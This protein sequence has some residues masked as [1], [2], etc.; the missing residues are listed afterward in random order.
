MFDE[1]SNLENAKWWMQWLQVHVQL[2]FCYFH[3]YCKKIYILVCV[4]D[5]VKQLQS[6]QCFRKINKKFDC[7]TVYEV[8]G[9]CM[10]NFILTC[11]KHDV[12][13]I[14]HRWG[15]CLLGSSHRAWDVDCEAELGSKRPC[16]GLWFHHVEGIGAGQSATWRPPPRGEQ[17]GDSNN[18]SGT[19]ERE[20]RNENLDEEQERWCL[21]M[22]QCDQQPA[23]YHHQM[24]M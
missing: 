12:P 17:P 20:T 11:C 7:D 16:L 22:I 10:L 3:T 2:T 19:P 6:Q 9:G 15:R 18:A 13:R 14:L 4:G 1:I 21:K 23:H 5:I 8:I 24:I